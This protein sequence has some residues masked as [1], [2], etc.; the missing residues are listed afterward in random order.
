VN[1]VCDNSINAMDCVYPV[2][3]L[4]MALSA[5][6]RVPVCMVSVTTPSMVMDYVYPVILLTMALTV[7]HRVPV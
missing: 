4:T 6:H 1:G 7:L 3:L 2:H 5:N